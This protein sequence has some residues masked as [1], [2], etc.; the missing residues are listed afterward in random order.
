MR[1]APVR[2]IFIINILLLLGLGLGFALGFLIYKAHTSYATPIKHVAQPQLTT[3]T[4]PPSQDL[5]EPFILPVPL[6]TKVTWKND[7]T[8]THLFTTTPT[9]PAQ[10]NFLNPQSFSFTVA[11]GKSVSFAFTHAGLYHYYEKT[12]STWNTQFARVAAH[13][14]VPR[15]PLAMDGIIWVEGPIKNLPAATLNQVPLNHDEFTL[16]FVAIN[17]SGTVVWHNFDTDPHFIALAPFWTAPINPTNIGIYR[18]AGTT[19]VPGG[20][21]VTVIFN[22]PGLYYYFC[23]NHD[24]FDPASYRALALTKASE[25]PLPM[26]GFVLVV[27]NS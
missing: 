2:L 17:Q 16:E 15:F 13:K 24:H 21:S 10:S 20:A 23:R 5:F 3:I 7:D 19:D 12:L 26:E 18:I 1:K 6:H 22:K 4:I 14:G 27:G 8:V 11:A 25:Y 9:T